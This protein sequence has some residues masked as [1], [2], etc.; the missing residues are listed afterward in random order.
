MVPTVRADE[1]PTRFDAEDILVAVEIVSPG[2]GRTDRVTK[3]AEYAEAGI[4]HYW[5]VEL[6]EPITLTAFSLVDGE[7]EQVAGGRGKIEIISPVPVSL[8]LAELTRR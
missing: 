4:P 8:D 5:L 1:N 7:Y 3:P 6:D 2:T